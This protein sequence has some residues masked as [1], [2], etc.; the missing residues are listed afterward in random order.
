MRLPT[1]WA[2]FRSQEGRIGFGVFADDRI[3]EYEGDLF[4]SPR[5]AGITLE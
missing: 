3:V 1:R 2:R 5:A 4:D